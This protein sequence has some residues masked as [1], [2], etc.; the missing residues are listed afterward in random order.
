[1]RL[2]KQR[3]LKIKL[4]QSVK[5]ESDTI[6]RRCDIERLKV[7]ERVPLNVG[8]YIQNKYCNNVV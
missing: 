4:I 2:E 8:N 5:S 7:Q 6:W 3:K 1:M